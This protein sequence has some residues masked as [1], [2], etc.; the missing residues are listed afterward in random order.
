MELD[1]MSL[2]LYFFLLSEPMSANEQLFLLIFF[3]ACCND[4]L[5]AQI[6]CRKFNGARNAD[7]SLQS[8]QSSFSGRPP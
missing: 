1:R 6:F 8:F 5:G 7:F 3:R 4:C 2:W